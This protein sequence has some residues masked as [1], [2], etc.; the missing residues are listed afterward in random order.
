MVWHRVASR[1]ASQLS[2][3]SSFIFYRF[4]ILVFAYKNIQTTIIAIQCDLSDSLKWWL[5][6]I[7]T[8]GFSYGRDIWNIVEW[9]SFITYFV[10]LWLQHGGSVKYDEAARIFRSF[11]FM[12]FAYQ[13]IRYGSIFETFGVLIPVL[14]RMV[15]RTWLP[16]ISGKNK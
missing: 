5:L 14:R 15:S 3:F 7:W 16:R 1:N 13:I 6:Q 2:Y 8:L 11:S 10:G 9:I 12:A 4:K